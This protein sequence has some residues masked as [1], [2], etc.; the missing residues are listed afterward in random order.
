MYIW[1]MDKDL[2]YLY[3]LFTAIKSID[4]EYCNWQH[5]G[6]IQKTER[7]FAYELYY[8]LRLISNLKSE[9]YKGI[10]FNGEIGKKTYETISNLGTQYTIEQ[11]DFN[12]DL[13]LHKS[14]IDRLSENQK[15]IV[16]IKTKSQPDEMVAKDI[17]KLNHGIKFLN[18]QFAIFISVNTNVN[19]TFT[20]IKNIF[21]IQTF[22]DDEVTNSKSI[23]IVNYNNCEL[24][25]ATLYKILTT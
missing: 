21:N 8:K 19:R 9:K 10:K 4:N 6:T 1:S 15:L 23:I 24:I 14:Q 5:N 13:V 11:N 20:K 3:D 18:F 12:P 25:T 17:I 16:E 7:V 22:S 2:E